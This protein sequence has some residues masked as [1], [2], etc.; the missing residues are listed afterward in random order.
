M[1]KGKLLDAVLCYVDRDRCFFTTQPLEKQWGD[2]WNDAPYEHNAGTPY[3]WCERTDTRPRYMVVE[4]VCCGPWD[5]PCEGLTSSPYSVQD[6]NRGNVAWLMQTDFSKA[7]PIY[8]GTTL[9]KF[10][11][12]CDEHDVSVF[13]PLD[14]A[15][16]MLAERGRGNAES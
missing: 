9:R 16:A 13:L 11:D 1:D 14:L 5:A 10:L 15:D 8:A 12:I 7:P 6:I 2:D 4:V 3:E